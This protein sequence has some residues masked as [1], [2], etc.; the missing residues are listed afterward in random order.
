MEGPL[1][2][3]ELSPIQFGA[4][5]GVPPV[6][7]AEVT[8]GL[9]ALDVALKIAP[10]GTGKRGTVTQADE[11]LAEKQRRVAV[12]QVLQDYPCIWAELR[13]HT[14]NGKDALIKAQGCDPSSTTGQLIQHTLRALRDGLGYPGAP[15]LEQLLIEHVTLAW[16]DFDTLQ[17]RY[18]RKT[19]E[20]HTTEA[21]LYWDRR[22]NSAQ[23]RYLRAVEELAR[24]RRLVQ[25]TPLQ[26][27]IGGQQV[28]VTG[29]TGPA[30]G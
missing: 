16:L 15:L 30:G 8:R 24:V 6:D 18:A 10:Q 26:V 5:Y 7:P 23:Q 27:N 9:E 21:G 19:T 3:G 1:R 25:V 14:T 17:I 11:L 12:R 29:T 13:H 2:P 28:N 20:S 4:Q 22:L